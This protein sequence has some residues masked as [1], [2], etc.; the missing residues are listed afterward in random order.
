M[1]Y[2]RYGKPKQIYVKH[3]DII[4]EFDH[5]EICYIYAMKTIQCAMYSLNQH[6]EALA[7]SFNIHL[8]FNISS[9]HENHFTNI[10]RVYIQH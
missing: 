10:W 7:V 6:Q 5:Y 1:N 3:T 9:M 2:H 8:S 4:H